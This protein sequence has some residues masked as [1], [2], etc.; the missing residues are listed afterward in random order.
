MTTPQRLGAIDALRGCAMVWMTLYHFAFDL[1]YFGFWKQD[2]YRDPLWT[3]QRNCILGL[4]LLCVGL[5][6]SV[7]AAQG[8]TWGRFW[9]RWWQVVA[10]AALVSFVSWLMFPR[11]FIY[12]GVLHGVA[13]M[14]LIARL[15]AG[16]SIPVLLA[17][18][19]IALVLPLAAS[20]LLQGSSVAVAFNTPLLNWLG[21]I[22]SKP[23]TEDYVPLLPWMAMVWC[24]M[25]A[26]QWLLAH[27]PQRLDGKVTGLGKFLSALGRWSLTYYLLHQPLM[28]G[29][30]MAFALL[31]RSSP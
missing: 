26:G 11:S 20:W 4:F 16:R 5:G 31:T 24:G 18:A 22:T 30:L 19:C 15:S 8:Q 14:S 21:F 12:F 23:I 25:A 13:V 3:W 10:S 6:Q 29:A 2:F 7:A 17:F 9:R 1:S 27:A 28:I